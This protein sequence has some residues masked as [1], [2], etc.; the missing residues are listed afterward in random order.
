MPRRGDQAGVAID[1]N[2]VE[3]PHVTRS[4]VDPPK[5]KH[6]L[7]RSRC[8]TGVICKGGVVATAMRDQG[9]LWGCPMEPAGLPALLVD[10]WVTMSDRRRAA[11]VGAVVAAA[12]AM[13]ARRMHPRQRLDHDVD[14]RGDLRGLLRGAERGG[15]PGHPGRRTARG[16]R[17]RGARVD[18]RDAD[19]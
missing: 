11:V 12:A 7:K 9:W 8:K 16:A 17:G 15:Q 3:N 14:D 4:A 18:G 13:G 6:Y 2:T 1:I 10:R 5:S 19:R